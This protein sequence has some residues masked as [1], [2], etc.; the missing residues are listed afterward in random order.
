[1]NNKKRNHDKLRIVWIC[2]FMNQLMKE[3]LSIPLEIKEFAPWIPLGIEEFRKMNDIELHVIAPLYTILKNARID[4]DNIHYHFIKV[5][6]PL[7][8]KPWPN[9]FEFDLISNFFPFN[10]MV[11]R[12]IS[13]IKPDIVN[14]IGAENAYYSSS[15]LGIKK[16]PVLVTI[17]GFVSLSGEAEPGETGI[18]RKRID[19]E[20]QILTRMK[21]FGIEATSIE[22]YIRNLN[23]SAKMYW[24][25][26][27]FAKT[28]VDIIPDKEYDIVFFARI[29]K[30]KG[31]E[32]AIKALSIAKK[33]KPDIKMEVIGKADPNY[34]NTLIQL[35]SDLDLTE[36]IEFKG[37]IPTQKEMHY[38]VLKARISIL[39]T[40]NDTIPGTIAESMLLGLPV[41]SYRTGGIPD[42]NKEHDNIILVD[43]GNIDGLSEEILKL[44]DNPQELADRGEKAKQYA[45]IEFDNANSARLM[46]KAYRE[47]INDNAR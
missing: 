35:V 13:K 7:S 2:H 46:V 22:K 14:L 23:P 27:P 16:Y 8:R 19:F 15:I 43:Q 5:G 38:E 6:R 39:P 42:I 45:T 20:R 3:K 12:L 24:F 30:M 40:Y 21:H 9:W 33:N 32:D 28:K 37:F 31:I 1:M 41:I 47:I 18:V 44:L 4:E 10:I 11:K 26:F 17:Q 36:N 29:I 25:H 34:M